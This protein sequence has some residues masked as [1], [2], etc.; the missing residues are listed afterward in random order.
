[1]KTITLWW[2]FIKKHFVPMTITAMLLTIAMFA[3][4]TFYGNYLYKAY[5]RD[6]L[7]RSNLQNGGY[8]MNFYSF[9]NN[10]DDDIDPIESMN[11]KYNEQKAMIKAFAA[12]KYILHNEYFYIGDTSGHNM[13]YTCFLYDKNHRLGFPLDVDEGRWLSEKPLYTEAVIAGNHWGKS[14]GDVLY[15]DGGIEATVV[16]IINGAA[17]CP[18]F[19]SSSNSVCSADHLFSTKICNIYIS[20]ETVEPQMLSGRKIYTP[21][22]CY[23][24]FDENASEE[25]LAELNSYLESQGVFAPYSKIISDSKK[26]IDEWL[27]L[28]FPL[29]L[30]LT[31]V[32]AISILCICTNITQRSLNEYS[33][34]YLL[35]CTKRRI[36][37]LVTAPMLIF[38]VL[39][40]VLNLLSVLVF[41]NFLRAGDD[42]Y[43]QNYI[44]DYR[45]A[46][47]VLGYFGVLSALLIIM[48]KLFYRNY[49]PLSLYR[50]N[51]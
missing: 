51:L 14:V 8:L 1:M 41:P 32:C 38:F 17:I 50:R 34:Y 19:G 16:G 25:N 11:I 6:V 2:S 36:V 3:V 20:E 48:P 31:V 15:L 9:D 7:L 37:F 21:Y 43:K 28:T 47:L 5:T 44:L 49:S 35:G 39:P 18:D 46:I 29:P 40:S 30:F 22:N 27:H 45:A 24:V 13:G 23:I 4:T 42:Y 26:E 12:C 10:E 33:K